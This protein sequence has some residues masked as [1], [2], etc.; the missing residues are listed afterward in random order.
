[1]IIDSCKGCD[2][3]I[4]DNISI[5]RFDAPHIPEICYSCYDWDIIDNERRNYKASKEAHFDCIGCVYQMSDGRPGIWA[6]GY[7]S[8]PYE[9]VLK[10]CDNCYTWLR[11]RDYRSNYKEKIF[12]KD[13]IIKIFNS[14][15]I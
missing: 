10:V 8:I 9:E 6:D 1:M 5:K 13:E 15:D 3:Q 4:D 14:I 7:K 12:P 2:Y 11:P